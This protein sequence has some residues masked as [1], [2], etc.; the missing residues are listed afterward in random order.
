MLGVFAGVMI[1]SSLYA[2]AHPDVAFGTGLSIFQPV[3]GGTGVGGTL[4]GLLKA[5]GTSPFTVATAGSDFAPPTSG[6]A[7]LKGNGSGGFSNAVSNSDYQAPIALT[8]SGSSGA[9]TFNGTTLNIPQYSGGGASSDFTY[10]LNF[11]AV[12]A[13]T[14]TNPIWA[15]LGV[16]ASSTSNFAK[17]NTDQYSGYYQNNRLL[18]YASSTNN[19]TIFGIGAGGNNAT[20][21]ATNKRLT[22]IGSGAGAALTSAA[23]NTAIGAVALSADITGGTNTA[24]GS[25]AMVNYTGGSSNVAVGYEAGQGSSGTPP[26]GL[27]NTFVGTLTGGQMQGAGNYDTLLGFSAGT[28]ITSGQQDT[29]IGTNQSAGG[30]GDLVSG[31]NDIGIGYDV[32]FPSNSITNS[33]NIGNFV[34]GTL[35][36][37]NATTNFTLPTSGA[38][39]VASGTPFATLSVQANNGGTNLSL[40]AIGSSTAS[41][42]TTLF[43]VS[44][45]GSTTIGNFGTCGGTQALTTNSSGTIVC[46][47][48]TGSGGSAYPF[49]PGLFG[50]TLTSATTTAISDT[51][52]IFSSSTSWFTSI[53]FGSA[54]GS[55]LAITGSTTIAGQLN[56]VFANMFG[57]TTLLGSTLL[58]NATT[59]S[60][61]IT[62]AATS[63]ISAGL[64]VS[65]VSGCL[66]VNGVCLNTS[67]TNITAYKAAVNY[68]T[69]GALPAN[70]YGGGV[71]TEVGTGALSVDGASPA[72]GNRILVKNEGTQTNNGIY[73]VTAT[74]SGIAAYV[75]TRASDFNTSADIYPG[76][77]TYVLS[78]TANNDDTWTLTTAAPVVLDTSNLTFLE[79]AT[80]GITLPLSTTNGGLG[81]NF[82]ASTGAL[83]ISGGTVTAGTLSVGNGGT[84]AASF[85]GNQ[86]IYT[87]SAGSAF[88]GTATSTFLGAL[89]TLGPAWVSLG[90]TTP[91]L[92]VSPAQL[93]VGTSTKSQLLLTDNSTTDPQFFMRTMPGG[94]AFGT[95]SP[96]T[97]A[98]STLNILTALASST[99]ATE[100][101]G[102]GTTTPRTTLDVYGEITSYESHPATST[103]MTV[104]WANT[105]NSVLLQIGTSATTVNFTGLGLGMTKAIQIGNPNAV[106]GAVTFQYTYN[107][108]TVQPIPC[109]GIAAQTTT[110]GHGDL[111]SFKTTIG[112]STT[113]LIEIEMCMT[114][115]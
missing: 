23:D 22:I 102:V 64:N 53:Q 83:S 85:S 8:T 80:G 54:T 81:G 13:A 46:G 115:F 52:G 109:T 79:S 113:G 92:T 93:I 31:T 112:T 87:N 41:A 100:L 104:D 40:F 39:G 49:T 16:N 56:S 50:P 86:I 62:G 45:T 19:D 110:S 68:A 26:S 35:P 17:I 89:G 71:L 43:S 18:A 58:T 72:V 66:A 29:L 44:N 3:Q 77:S 61:A 36:A 99:A 111:W 51:Q 107:G 28:S 103:T 82:G 108:N 73:V 70:T 24:I 10:L 67:I 27:D 75:L 101:L 74:G 9:A 57:S 15:Q 21:S 2:L 78:G 105:P 48:I 60:F 69:T 95:T 55:A 33:L 30:T 84:G 32:A 7:L 114:P 38:L 25:N 37:A 12:N 59:T 1:G 11:G 88:T 14:S 98:T 96:T 76:V 47:T 90:T 20:T 5:N 97:L 65:T 34:Y 4:T 63:T 6:S 42:T 106:A 94:W 91:L